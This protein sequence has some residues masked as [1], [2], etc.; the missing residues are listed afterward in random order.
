MEHMLDHMVRSNAEKLVSNFGRQM[1]IS[2]MPGKAHELIGIFVPD[3]DNK[4]GGGLN[5]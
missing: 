3:F 5:L 4:L 1:P 2:Q